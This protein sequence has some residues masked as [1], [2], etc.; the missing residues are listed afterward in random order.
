MPPVAS[1]CIER[2]QG[3]EQAGVLRKDENENMD[4]HV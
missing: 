1:Y 4:E 2:V 3:E